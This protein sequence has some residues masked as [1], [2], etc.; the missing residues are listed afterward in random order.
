[1]HKKRTTYPS[2]NSSTFEELAES[3]SISEIH[4]R[5]LQT[6]LCFVL[7]ETVSDKDA[8]LSSGGLILPFRGLTLFLTFSPIADDTIRTSPPKENRLALRSHKALF[9]NWGLLL[10]G[11]TSVVAP[12]AFIFR[13]ALLTILC[14][15]QVDMVPTPTKRPRQISDVIADVA[16]HGHAPWLRRLLSAAK[17]N[18]NEGARPLPWLTPS[19]ILEGSTLTWLSSGNTRTPRPNKSLSFCPGAIIIGVLEPFVV[20]QGPSRV[21]FVITSSS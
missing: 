7:C 19:L 15:E 5:T 16:P 2:A 6:R 18:N 10:T 12:L 3:F 1:M 14:L 11:T 8:L 4:K 20:G 21:T 13:M 17:K 9:Y